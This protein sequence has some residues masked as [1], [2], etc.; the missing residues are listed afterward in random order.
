MHAKHEVLDRARKRQR[1]PAWH[2]KYRATVRRSN[3]SQKLAH[4]MRRNHGA[5]HAA[6][7]GTAA[8]PRVRRTDA[9][10][11]VVPKVPMAS[12]ASLAGAPGV[13]SPAPNVL[14]VAHWADLRGGLR[15]AASCRIAWATSGSRRRAPPQKLPL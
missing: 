15:F 10:G 8:Q 12:A 13:E 2:Q 7:V 3:G 1:D 4:M 14:S 6:R 9:R 5:V 11:T